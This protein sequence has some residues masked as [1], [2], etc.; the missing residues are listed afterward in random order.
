M[1]RSGVSTSISNIHHLYMLR[2]FTLL[3][4]SYFGIYH[5]LVESRFTLLC[6][7]KPEVTLLSTFALVLLSC[8]SPAS[9]AQLLISSF[10]GQQRHPRHCT[11]GMCTWR[12]RRRLLWRPI[13]PEF[14]LPQSV[15]VHLCSRSEPQSCSSFPRTWPIIMAASS[16]TQ[17]SAT[18]P[19]LQTFSF[20]PAFPEDSH[21]S[22]STFQSSFGRAQGLWEGR[23]RWGSNYSEVH[24][25]PCQ[26]RNWFCLK[27]IYMG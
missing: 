18:F 9:I 4:P 12:V 26:V 25:S 27:V 3:F 13:I 11:D 23:G 10:P 8:L 14:S 22:S 6:G 16:S 15:P 1:I 7:G 5:R 24:T 21:T 20:P 17:F 19:Q 2:T